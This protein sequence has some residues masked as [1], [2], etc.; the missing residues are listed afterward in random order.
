MSASS[1]DT[2]PQPGSDT[3]LNK[4][5]AQPD[6]QGNTQLDTVDTPAQAGSP[7]PVRGTSP[8]RNPLW[9][10]VAATVACVVIVVTTDWPAA[11]P[12]EAQEPAA[13][14]KQLERFTPTEGD[15]VS[16]V[17]TVLSTTKAGNAEIILAGAMDENP[18]VRAAG[19][20]ALANLLI[21]MRSSVDFGR[22]PPPELSMN[23]K[24]RIDAIV[25]TG[26]ANPQDEQF[27]LYLS[28]M[29]QLAVEGNKYHQAALDALPLGDMEAQAY[30]WL[31][32]CYALGPRPEA[33]EFILQALEPG[34][35]PEA[36]RVAAILCLYL[37]DESL[38]EPLTAV[39]MDT[40]RDATLRAMAIY[41]IADYGAQ[42]QHVL[43]Q[44]RSLL[45]DEEIN[46]TDSSIVASS[47]RIIE[48]DTPKRH[49]QNLHPSG[50]P[51]R[52]I[53]PLW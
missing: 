24:E 32:L 3:P 26:L 5:D 11:E 12:F 25:L 1:H 50:G 39:A 31:H 19:L 47:I 17:P 40:D 43:P 41:A 14:I 7:A 2:P 10:A 9:F 6:T 52:N 23:M 20:K 44:L 45:A 34:A 27:R 48:Q 33:K 4:P 46:N 38:I 28:L 53:N 36:G 18:A 42:A 29:E 8:W 13:K 15:A 37:L 51:W 22:N 30:I 49:M 21:A 16:H 35:P